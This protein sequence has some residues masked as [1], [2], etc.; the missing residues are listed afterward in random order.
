MTSLAAMRANARAVLQ[1]N[2]RGEF[3]TPSRNQYPHQWNWDSALIALGLSHFDMP[4]A[5]VEIRS[6]LRAQ[7]RDGMVPHIIYHHGAS[8]YFPPPDFWQTDSL[9]HGGTIASSGLTQPPVLAIVV[10]MLHERSGGGDESLAFLR[11]VFPALRGWHRWLHQSRSPDGSGLPCLIHP[12]ESGT[13]N[14]PRW[15]AALDRISPRDLPE[16]R[17]RDMVHV[18]ADER[19][20]AKDY[21]RFVFLI[22]QD[23]L[24][25]WDAAWLM[26]NSPFLVQDV[27]FCS[28]L[29]RADEDL[30]AIAGLL[31]EDASEIAG[32]IDQT[33][34]VFNGRFWNETRGLYLDYDMRMGAPIPVNTFVTFMPL[35]AGL[36]SA[37]QSARL[38]TEHW[39]NPAEYAP[40]ADSRY[41]IPSTSKQEAAYNPRRYWCGPVWIVTNWLMH[42]GLKRYGLTTAARDLAADSRTLVETR[43]FYE[44]Y[45]PRDGQGLGAPDFSWPAALVLE[46][47]IG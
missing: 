4:R 34:R 44:Y 14:S 33:R 42:Q 37:Q 29:H 36:A 12:W 5:R 47:W 30:L 25:G 26:A 23:R 27:M 13:D 41:R 6:L 1:L 32:W 38:M 10:R 35:I 11:E 15:A 2:N 19:P 21:E 22:D 17:R 3:T 46:G 8:D 24:H 9:A 40:G 43:G 16:F 18:A 7:W 28:I 20:L 45:D 31:G 39:D